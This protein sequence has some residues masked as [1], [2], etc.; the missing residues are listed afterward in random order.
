[1]NT[2]YHQKY[3]K[4]WQVTSWT[5]DVNEAGYP[6]LVFMSSGSLGPGWCMGLLWNK[7][8]ANAAITREQ[9]TSK[10]SMSFNKPANSNT[11]TFSSG[12]DDKDVW[13]LSFAR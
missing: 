2:A 4:S 1:M 9:G 7:A 6:Y 5:T 11:I 10:G 8:T 12:Q 13:I 3:W